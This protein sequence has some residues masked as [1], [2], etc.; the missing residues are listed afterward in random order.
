MSASSTHASSD[1]RRALAFGAT[2]TL[3]A[4]LGVATA[5]PA[6]AAT[7]ECGPNCISVFNAGLGPGFV[8]A[9]LDGGTA[10][11]GQPVGLSPVSGTDPS[12]DF[13]PGGA[14]NTA[15]GQVALVSDFFADG[16]VSAEVNAHYMDFPAVQ[17]KYAPFGEETGLCVGVERVAQNEDLVLIPC[18][19]PGTTVWIVYP[20]SPGPTEPFAIVNGGTTDF[21]R[22]FAMHLPVNETASGSEQLQ[23]ELRHLQFLGDDDTLRLRQLW[24]AFFGPP[25]QG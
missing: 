2:L 6:Q 4:G 20:V 3:V 9:V 16:M 10:Q 12:L 14:S 23:M 22:P 15:P 24:L 13:L 19:V 11:I 17:Q 5:A 8:E 7:P 21:D 1:R 18:D 25:P